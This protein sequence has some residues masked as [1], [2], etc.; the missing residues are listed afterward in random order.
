MDT[1]TPPACVLGQSAGQLLGAASLLHES[2]QVLVLD[3]LVG[4]T[5]LDVPL[6]GLLMSLPLGADGVLQAFI[7]V[8]LLEVHGAV[9]LGA[10]L[11]VKAVL[12]LDKLQLALAT[13]SRAVEL[14][15]NALGEALKPEMADDVG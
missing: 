14:V 10:N 7:A 9:S 12:G 11:S 1:H 13:P 4:S 2:S 5:S 8:L 3:I 6:P 15:P